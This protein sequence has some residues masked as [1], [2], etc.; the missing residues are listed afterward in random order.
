MFDLFEIEHLTRGQLGT[1]DVPCPICGPERR[2]PL[3]C[4]R[5]VLR[6][7]HESERFASWHCARCGVHGHSR[8]PK[9]ERPDPPV[10]ER[11]RAEAAARERIS[12]TDRHVRALW[13][14]N[15]RKP[16]TGSIAEKYLRAR[17]YAGALPGTLGFLPGR[18]N[19]GPAMIGAFGMAHEIEPG[20]IEIETK[21]VTGVHL[22]RLRPDGE[23][24]A[25]SERDK[26]MVG[27]SI[28][29]AIVLAPPND[30]LGLVVTEGIE[31]GLSA[32][33]ATNLGAWAAGS[34]SRLPALAD[35]IPAYIECVSLI[36]DDDDAGR[37]HAAVL[38]DLVEHRGIEVH[39]ILPGSK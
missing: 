34:A 2:S 27:S 24:K 29:S 21:A 31:D 37:H 18:G 20:T 14:W 28:G 8:D 15:H 22:T 35:A 23:G 32:Y 3:N 7:W 16:I 11:L 1:H 30:L 36:A 4:R 6:I 12:I 10:L 26:I 33:A 13:L 9:A 17:G 5:P 25:G 19:H 39:L 38:G